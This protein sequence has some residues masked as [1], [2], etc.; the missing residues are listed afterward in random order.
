[1]LLS[2]DEAVPVSG[3][4]NARSTID[5]FV[6]FALTRCAACGKTRFME[7]C[8]IVLLPGRRPPIRGVYTAPSLPQ[9]LLKKV[10]VPPPTFHNGFCG[11]TTN[12]RPPARKRY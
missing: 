10:G 9:S 5:A 8:L 11:R 7:G 4:C 3:A 6:W 12:R 1:M 2:I